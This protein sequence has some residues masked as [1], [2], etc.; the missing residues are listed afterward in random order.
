MNDELLIEL[1]RSRP[2]LYDSNNRDYLNAECKKKVWL[3]I[4]KEMNVDGKC[5]LEVLS[6][7]IS[8]LS[9]SS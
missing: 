2:V 6:L 5:C 3:E 7:F 9:L 1:V 4:G 8:I